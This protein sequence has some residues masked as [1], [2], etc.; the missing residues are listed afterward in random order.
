MLI[1]TS[2]LAAV[3]GT[4]PVAAD[5]RQAA[6]FFSAGQQAFEKQDYNTAIRAFEESLRAKP[7]PA[8]V[9]A[10]AQAHRMQYG[11][12]LNLHNLRRAIDLYRRFVTEQ[13]GSRFRATA[14]GHLVRLLAILARQPAAAASQP[15]PARPPPETQLMI[16]S[17]TPGARVLIDGEP[18]GGEAVPAIRVVSAGDHRVEVTAPLHAR[19]SRSV[20]AVKHRLILT[21]IDLEPLPGGLRVLSSLDGATVFIDGK[22][23]GQTPFSRSDLAPGKHEVAVAHR[24][25]RLWNDSVEIEPGRT[26]STVANLRWSTRRKASVL[27]A[28]GGVA[29]AIA[30]LVTGLLALGEDSALAGA[31]PTADADRRAWDDR[32]DRRDRLATSSTVLLGVAGAA[33][34]GAAALYWFDNPDPPK[35]ARAARLEEQLR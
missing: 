6:K 20:M 12:D 16:T 10:L 13:P 29:A 23:L 26:A 21:N 19:Q 11:Q 32:L 27:T 34:V 14:D 31:P 22:S 33:L 7:H 25:R 24:G 15:A 35:P 8:T 28:G 30:G 2:V 17:S 18:P 5:T 3:S 4:Q 9:Y 1:V